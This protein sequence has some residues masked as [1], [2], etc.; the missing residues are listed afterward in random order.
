MSYWVEIDLE[1]ETIRVDDVDNV[2]CHD[3]YRWIIIDGTKLDFG[4]KVRVRISTDNIWHLK[5]TE[6]TRS[7][8]VR[9]GEFY[10]DDVGELFYRDK[11]LH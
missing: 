3:F 4:Q 2:C 10:L 11:L 9:N 1:D 8:V 7:V 6:R 5:G